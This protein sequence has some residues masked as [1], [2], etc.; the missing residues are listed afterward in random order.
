MRLPLLVLCLLPLACHHDSDRKPAAGA[1]WV[2]LF[3]GETT[4]GWRGFKRDDVPAGWQVVDGALTRVDGGGDLITE[5]MFGDFELELEWR[6][7]PAGNS[8]IMFRI[9]EDFDA[10]YFT[11]PEMQVLDDTG[12][13]G[14]DPR[15]SAGANYALHAPVG[16]QLAPVGEW[17]RVRIVARGAH[18]EHWLNGVKVV[19]Y[20]LWSPEWTELVANSKFVEWPRY[21]K[22]ERG[23]IG[24]QDHGNEVA[25]RNIRIRPLTQE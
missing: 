7:T 1:A 10:T 15:H 24:L 22:N 13:E 18:V 14:L 23:H 2:S 6:I 20:E 5:E 8:G 25:Y 17:N 21:G 16:K 11:A 4:D 19:E 3:D 9:T 12:H